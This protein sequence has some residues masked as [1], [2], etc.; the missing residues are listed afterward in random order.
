MNKRDQLSQWSTMVADSGDL[1]VIA[2]LAPE[3]ATTNPS[4]LLATAENPA[5]LNLLSEAQHLANQLQPGHSSPGHLVD[6]FACLCGKQLTESVPGWVSTEVDARLSF[7]TKATVEKARKLIQIY[8]ELGVS[9]D[10]ILIKIASTWEGIRAAEVLEEE[11]I[12]CNLTLL[13]SLEQAIAAAEAGAT[14]ISPFVGRILDWHLKHGAKVSSADEDPGVLSVRRI[15]QE[16]KVREH[17]TIIMGASF[18][19]R[20]QI[21]A[22]AGCDRLTIAPALLNE[23]TEDQGKLERKLSPLEIEDPID[24][25]AIKEDEFRLGLNN[26]AMATELLA[27]G[28]RRFIADQETLESLMFEGM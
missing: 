6:A 22:L 10:R 23:L 8:R 18:R 1:D 17:D 19:N 13:F 26:N 3:D 24:P 20:G 9:Q 15:Y 25:T 11:G 21:E 2:Q 27:D 28:I 7:N 5:Y 14:L 4:L 12:S 16:L